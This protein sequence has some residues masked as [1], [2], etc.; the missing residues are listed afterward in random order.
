MKKALTSLAALICGMGPLLSAPMGT[1]FNYQGRLDN[2]NGPVTGL[3]DFHFVLWNSASGPS[4]I[5]PGLE[6]SATP[7]TNGLFTAVLDFGNVFDGEAR[8]LQVL[9]CTNGAG[10]F[11]PLYPRQ[12]LT[13]TPYAL[14]SSNAANAVNAATAGSANTALSAATANVANLVPLNALGATNI[15]PGQVVKSLNGL[16][17]A[18]ILSAGTNI[19]LATNGSSLILGAG[20]WIP[21][22]SNIYYPNRVGIG[23]QP[24]S[25]LSPSLEVAGGVGGPTSGSIH[26]GTY[27]AGG[28][29]KLINFGDMQNTTNGYVSIGENGADDTMELRASTFFFKNGVVG[30]GT[31]LPSANLEVVGSVRAGTYYGSG[32]GLTGLSAA[33]LSSGTVP[34]TRLSANIALLNNNQTFTGQKN[35]SQAVGIGTSSPYGALLDVEGDIR[36]NLHELLFAHGTDL[37]HGVGWYGASKLWGGVNIDGPVLYGCDGGALGSMCSSNLALRWRSSGNVIIDPQ[38]QNAGSITPGLTFGDNSGEG[39][40]SRRT[41]GANQYGLDFYTVYAPRMSIDNSGRVGIG[42]QTPQ[43]ALDVVGSMQVGA[44]HT[45]NGNYSSI[46]GGANNAN[47]GSFGFVGG[48]INNRV[49]NDCNAILGGTNN[50]VTGFGATIGGGQ[51]NRIPYRY[52]SIINPGYYAT[53]VGGQD[54]VAAGWHSSIGGGFANLTAWNYAN[55]SGGNSN[56]SMSWASTIGGGYNNLASNTLATAGSGACTVAGGSGNKAVGP[57][58]TVGGGMNNSATADYSVVPGGVANVASGIGSFAGGYAAKASRDGMFVWADY[59]PLVVGG[60]DPTIYGGGGANSFNVRATGGIY[61]MTA[62]DAN[63]V[64]TQGPVCYAGSGA[65]TAY[66]DRN[67]KEEFESVDAKEI[68]ERLASIPITTWK[69]KAQPASTRHIGPVAQDFKAAFEVGETERGINS[70]DADGVALAA[71]QGLNKKVDEQVQDKDARIKSLE[72][73]VTELQALVEKLVNQSGAKE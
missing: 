38:N 49:T 60:Y 72:Q 52:G 39:I 13:P 71:I 66:C 14:F 33:S 35:F 58:S 46:A 2:T 8:W 29:P 4:Q 11:I 12:L 15:Q 5:G 17:D 57:A 63:G 37:N 44:N 20:P 23:I 31:N 41:P 30:I 19:T 3:Y 34:D 73:R 67:G 16:K 65:F 54:N 40:A 59:H 70:I 36:L 51:N 56:R 10:S 28:D 7:V 6:L 61:F 24:H 27:A 25:S 48:G 18:V 22:Y 26:V 47:A 32:E 69:Y 62:V 68:L 53:I 43:V 55:V 50:N 21:W 1:A 9:V 45:I 42:T 64:A